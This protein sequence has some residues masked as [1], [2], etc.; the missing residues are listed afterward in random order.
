[1]THAGADDA[2]VLRSERLTMRTPR[3]SDVASLTSILSDPSVAAWWT[4]YGEPRVRNELIA[5]R[6]HTQVLIMELDDTI[7]GAIQFNEVADP[8]YFH[9]GVDLF[10]GAPWQNRGL[11]TEA[12]RA[13]VRYLFSVRGH[14]RVVGDPAAHNAPSIRAF[15]KAGFRRAGVMRRYERSPDG[16]FHDGV[17]MEILATDTA[18]G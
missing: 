2:P 1:M 13:V 9:A 8:Q 4:G 10:I 18:A 5:H 11:G 3:E 16:T 15:E 14:H 6:D 12:I 7:A 17:L